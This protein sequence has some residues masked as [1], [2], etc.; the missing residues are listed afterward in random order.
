M[1]TIEAQG[2]TKVAAYETT[3]LDVDFT[4]LKNAT[5][6]WKKEGSPMN[7]KD[8]NK[9]ITDYMT[10]NKAVGAYIV[11][12]GSAKDT[13][14]RPYS[15]INEVTEGKRKSKRVYQI[16][17]ASFKTKTS[18][19]VDAEGNTVTVKSVDPKS[20]VLGVVVGREGKKSEALA[21]AK[22]LTTLN[23]RAYGIEIVEEIVEGQKYAAFVEY[24]PSESAK[25]GKFIF[26]NKEA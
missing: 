20:V 1:R 23:K 22:K 18:E 12:D 9:F 10:T 8:L 25:L 6:K 2:F 17:E 14:I 26:F 7:T 5:Q 24:T 21:T 13:R 19:V 16:K 3:G 15:V 11:V 4:L